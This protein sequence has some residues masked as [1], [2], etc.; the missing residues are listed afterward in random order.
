[1]QNS[2]EK[3]AKKYKSP[4]KNLHEIPKVALI[5]LFIY[6]AC[7]IYKDEYGIEHYPLFM[8]MFLWMYLYN[9]F[10][11]KSREIIEHGNFIDYYKIVR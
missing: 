8:I 3:L 4:P 7:N 1:M 2:S 11:E 10:V 6:I 5:S 9:K